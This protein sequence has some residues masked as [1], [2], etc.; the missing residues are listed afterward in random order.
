MTRIFNIQKKR[1][2]LKTKKQTAK[3]FQVLYVCSSR[4]KTLSCDTGILIHGARFDQFDLVACPH[5]Q[6]YMVGCGV[7]V[8]E[9][10]CSKCHG[11]TTCRLLASKFV[12]GNPCVGTSKYLEVNYTC[13]Q[14]PYGG[15]LINNSGTHCWGTLDLV[16][17]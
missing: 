17:W 9:D 6:I 2:N 3:G 11:Q 13:A 10:V 5:S 14:H 16:V 15:A 7:D 12:Y 8:E 4:E 1:K